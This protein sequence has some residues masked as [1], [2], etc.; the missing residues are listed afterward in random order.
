MYEPTNSANFVKR[1]QISF[2]YNSLGA[3]TGLIY[4]NRLIVNTNVS[5]STNNSQHKSKSN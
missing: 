4:I 3:N 2:E 1:I 5:G